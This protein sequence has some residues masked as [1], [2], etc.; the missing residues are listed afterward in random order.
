[1]F[2]IQLWVCI[3]KHSLLAFNF[4]LVSEAIQNKNEV[5]IRFTSV[6]DDPQAGA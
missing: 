6:L 2:N 1:M 5:F 4:F 3:E